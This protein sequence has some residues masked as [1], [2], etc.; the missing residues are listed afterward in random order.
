MTD[1]RR[2]VDR[3]VAD[4]ASGK[5]RPGDRLPPQR[6][7]A[8]QQGIATSTASRAYGELARRGLIV[9]EV[10][11]GTYVRTMTGTS[12]PAFAEPGPLLVNLEFNMPLPA[13][14]GRLLAKSLAPFL[15]RTAALQ[16]VLLASA[17]TGTIDARHTVAKFLS[18]GDWTV[19]PDCVRFAGNGKQALGAAMAA[20]VPIGQRLGVDA[21]TYPV[22]KALAARLG[23]ELVPLRMDEQ[24]I[25]PDALIAAQRKTPMRAIYCQPALH[26]PLGI[27]MPKIRRLEIV[28]V[29]QRHD[30]YAI[31]DHVYAFLADDL[32]P[33]A[34]LAPDRTVLVDS[35]SKR[36][37]PGI[38]LGY[39]SA[40]PRLTSQIE[41]A[42]R[43]G[44]WGPSAL[45]MELCTRW[46]ADGTV[47]V[48][49]AAKRRDAEARQRILHDAFAGLALQSN[50]RAYHAW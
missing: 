27:T 43:S 7:F 42:V 10:G 12:I 40:P 3:V 45:S 46:I 21:L 32:A 41:A 19:N 31:E 4:I 29:L 44:A 1:Y 47:A 34:A 5:L 30:L 6:E 23:I 35:L 2:V 39:I 8:D 26:N 36:L 48:V 33:L 13:D 18:R 50:P 22:V 28:A 16:R 37:V 17:A 38:T 14:Q 9:G 49:S 15:K 24:G 20:L 11:R 25:R